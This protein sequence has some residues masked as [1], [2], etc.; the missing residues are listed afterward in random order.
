MDF[1]PTINSN[2]IRGHIDTIIL[3]SLKD[4]DKFPQQI[5]DSVFNVSDEKYEINQATLYSSLKRLESLKFVSSYWFDADDGRRKF[6]SLTELGRKNLEENLLDWSF[7]KGVIDKLIGSKTEEAEIKVVTVE[8]PVYIEKNQSPILSESVL[9]QNFEPKEEKQES[10]KVEVKAVENETVKSVEKTEAEINYRSIINGLIEVTKPVKQPQKPAEVIAVAKPKEQKPLVNEIYS[11]S[12]ER[13]GTIKPAV[14]KGT[15]DLSELKIKAK[16]EGF[17]LR[18]SSEKSGLTSQAYYLNKVK[19]F[20]SFTV[21]LIVMIQFLA[22]AV[23]FKSLFNVTPISIIIPAVFALFFPIFNLVSYLKNP[24]KITNKPLKK[25]SVFTA[26]IIVFN[27]ILITF[28]VD[29]LANVNL[30]E[31]YYLLLGF[32]FPVTLFIDCFIYFLIK[33]IISKRKD[34]KVK[35]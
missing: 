22:Y 15:V 8:K 2:L 30:K 24:Q 4:G 3:H 6:Y 1:Q 21:M 23:S 20:A 19:L 5:C 7:S 27:L 33:F 28:A 10:E 35:K 14:K 25:D 17:K 29:L 9:T 11:E 34:F 16:N 31:T 12:L 18:I 26:L 32:V 13:V